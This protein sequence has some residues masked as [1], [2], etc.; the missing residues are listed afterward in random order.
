MPW[1]TEIAV[2]AFESLLV[3]I[4]LMWNFLL[5]RDVIVLDRKVRAVIEVLQ[6]QLHGEIDRIDERAWKR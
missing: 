1:W 5:T 3:A 2:R 6:S 4:L